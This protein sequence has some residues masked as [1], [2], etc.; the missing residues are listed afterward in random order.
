MGLYQE[1]FR[2]KK[3]EGQIMLREAKPLTRCGCK[4]SL[5]VIRDLNSGKYIVSRFF[6]N[7]NHELH[8]CMKSTMS[9]SDKTMLALMTKIGF[10]PSQ[11]MHYL[12]QLAGGAG[13]LSFRRK[14][15][16]NWLNK[17]R[18]ERIQ[19]GDMK[20]VINDLEELKLK[21][22]SLF[23]KY[24]SVEDGTLTRL[25]WCDGCSRAE[26]KAFGDVLIFDST[27]KTNKYLYPLVIFSGAMGGKIPEVVLTNQDA[28]MRSTIVSE[29]VGTRHMICSWHLCRNVRK[30]IKNSAFCN[31]FFSLMDLNCSIEE[32]ELTWSNM[33]EK[34]NL[35]N[36][37]WVV[38]TYEIRE[39]CAEAYFGEQFMSMMTT[40][41]R[42]ESVNALIK[43][44]VDHNM[45]I[46]DF[47]DHYFRTLQR[48]RS[49]FIEM[50]KLSE[51]D[52]HEVRESPLKRLE[53]QALSIYTLKIYFLIR[54]EIRNEQGVVGESRSKDKNGNEI[55]VYRENK[56]IEVSIHRVIA[57]ESLSKFQCDC[58]K[59][60]SEGISCRHIIS[61]LKYYA[62]KKF[63]QYMIKRRWSKEVGTSLRKQFPD[64]CHVADSQEHRF[65]ELNKECLNL[66]FVSSQSQKEYSNSLK[67]VREVAE[68][69]NDEIMMQS[70]CGSVPS[71][72]KVKV[73]ID[74]SNEG[75][76][77]PVIENI[78][79]F[80]DPCRKKSRGATGG[81][82]QKC[83]M[84]GVLGHKSTTC[85]MR[86]PSID[87]GEKK[88][89]TNATPSPKERSTRVDNSTED[90]EIP[91]QEST[92]PD[93]HSNNTHHLGSYGPLP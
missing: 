17:L 88:K 14:S 57:D 62:I 3:E 28:A 63:P 78:T 6:N 48:L 86:D 61:T 44:S 92:H 9:Q 66:S 68:M 7:H 16:Y 35:S 77:D 29:F 38:D 75:L 87:D 69:A 2:G 72:N 70:Q 73:E 46:T 30:N 10:K 36:N 25:F 4:A 49:D 90:P 56:E 32:F 13:K 79:T 76:Q 64:P 65:G 53:E 5:R 15:G 8:G 89:K 40:M 1:G 54:K 33:V 55:F 43:L 52:E 93:S 26:Y 91:S 24:S 74:S 34:H 71:E 21:D 20:T 23:Y 81:K 47:L 18:A 42:A 22:A 80:R 12:E 31:D 37:K 59:L 82:K 84:C 50:Q 19:K 39:R 83:G 58:F 41:Q 60:E 85:E 45:S 51:Q 11:V 67:R 27:Y